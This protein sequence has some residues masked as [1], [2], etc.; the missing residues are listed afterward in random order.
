[1]VWYVTFVRFFLLILVVEFCCGFNWGL[2]KSDPCEKARKSLDELPAAGSQQRLKQEEGIL[3]TCPDGAAGRFVRALRAE[4]SGRADDAIALY[5]EVVAKDGAMAPAHGNLGL[6]LLEKGLDKEASVELTKGIM[7]RPDPRY[8]RALGRIMGEGGLPALA[9][10]HYSSARRTF[11]DD[12]TIHAGCAK[13]YEDLKQYDKA[14]NEYGQLLLLKPGDAAAR[15]GLA[16]V[17]RKAG[18][19]DQAAGQLRSYIA[20]NVSDPKGHKLLADVLMEKGDR[21]AA[22]K[23]YLLAGIDVTIDPEDFARKGDEFMAERDYG[24]AITAYQ[25]AL[26]GRSDW[27]GVRQKLGDAQMAAGHDDDAAATFTALVKAGAKDGANLYR[28]G[29]LNERRGQLDEALSYYRAALGSDPSNVNARRRLAEIATWRGSFAE[30]A[31]Q[32]RELIRTRGDNPL[33]HLNLGRVYVQSKDPKN[34]IL[35]YEEAVHLDP[36]SREGHRELARLLMR[37]SLPE[38][39]E[40]HYREVIRLDP[41]DEEARNAL[42]TLYVKQKRLD[43]LTR[44]VKDWLERSPDDP[45]RHYR[46]GIVYEFKKDYE[47][48]FSEYK[49]SLELKPD[50][51]RALFALGRTYLKSGRISEAREM[52]EASRRADP[53]L[54]EPQLLLSSIKS[55]VPSARKQKAHKRH[56]KP[57]ARKRNRGR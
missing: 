44:L 23:E 56:D 4:R 24:K 50:N 36:T 7:G 35:E 38:K 28:L 30:A 18:R 45:Q 27:S 15:I 20:A 53:T 2:G 1:M 55:D 14:A 13:A 25:T 29:L 31:E 33:Y 57:K 22:R 21:E 37:R 17:Y 9:L 49:K 47:Q 5:R 26:K 52:L 11:P 48:A 39:A 10:F 54:A 12:A 34:A 19:L 51:A 8:H 46:L 6:L 3:K 40:Y 16:G 32:Y 42:I 43:D 41:E